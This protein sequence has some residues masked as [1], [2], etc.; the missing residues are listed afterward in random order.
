MKRVFSYTVS[1]GL[2][3]HGVSAGLAQTSTPATPDKK[4]MNTTQLATFGGGCFWCMEAVFETFNGVKAVT[5]GYTGGTMPNPT[6]KAVCGGDTG[7][8]EVIQIEFDPAQISYDQLLDIF[9]E[10]HDAT[11]MNRQG[12]D[13]GTQYRSAIFYHDDAQ[14]A[15]A[16]KSKAA[17][18]KKFK[19]PIVTEISPLPKF[20]PAEEYHQDYFRKNPNAPYCIVVISP[21]LQKLRKLKKH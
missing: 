12:A 20:Y 11:T 5:S 19:D 6:Y 10:A 21:K 13:S 9:W 17:A 18:A 16:L 8:A 15:A 4:K 14:K 2:L 3:L 7:H 1:L